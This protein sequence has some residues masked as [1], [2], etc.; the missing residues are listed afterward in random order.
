MWKIISNSEGKTTLIIPVD[1]VDGCG[2]AFD[3]YYH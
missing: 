2:V 3:M 1:S